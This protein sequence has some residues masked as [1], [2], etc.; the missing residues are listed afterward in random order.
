MSSFLY[1][2]ALLGLDSN[3]TAV[4][5]AIFV[6]QVQSA[7]PGHSQTECLP[8]QT[9]G[10]GGPTAELGGKALPMREAVTVVSCTEEQGR[11]QG[12]IKETAPAVPS[13]PPTG[14]AESI[15]IA[16]SI[17]VGGSEPHIWLHIL[18]L[19]PDLPTPYGTSNGEIESRKVVSAFGERGP[20]S[21][22]CRVERLKTW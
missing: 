5:S 20:Q 16:P 9:L 2:S 10:K 8:R 19:S 4:G 17:L 22:L 7:A 14:W 18:H 13:K 3:F 6:R 12:H 1:H 15:R 21:C 11:G